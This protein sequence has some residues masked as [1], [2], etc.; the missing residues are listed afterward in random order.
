MRIHVKLHSRFRAHLPPEA[1]GEASLDLP[2]GTTVGQLLDH[3][4]IERRVKLISINGCKVDDREWILSA[5]DLVRIFP[6]VV[7]G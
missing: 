5:G 2:E 6:M 1:H 4:A 3:L 7:G